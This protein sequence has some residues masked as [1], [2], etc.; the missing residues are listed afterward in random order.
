M[1]KFLW[2]MVL[3][4]GINAFAAAAKPA[5]TPFR[6]DGGIGG[7]LLLPSEG[8][9]GLIYLEPK[10]EII[11]KLGIGLRFELSTGF[12][13]GEEKVGMNVSYAGFLSADYH[14]NNNAFR[15][16]AGG[17]VGVYIMQGAKIDSND[18]DADM[19]G[20]F[21]FFVRGGFDVHH[22]RLALT[23]TFQGEHLGQ[24][25]QYIALNLGFYIGG[26]LKK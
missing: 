16:F 18:V 1:K 11:P 5:F 15:P 19:S 12:F 6:F 21:S 17:G 25:H 26:G 3:V 23:Y 13:A 14:F 22:F 24:I 7:G 8:A 9:V 2:A 20:N 4:V 10:Y